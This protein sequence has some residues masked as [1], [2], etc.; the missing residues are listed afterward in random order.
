MARFTELPDEIKLQILGHLITPTQP[1]HLIQ[2][3]LWAVQP[4][5]LFADEDADVETS[6]LSLVRSELDDIFFE[7]SQEDARRMWIQRVQWL[8]TSSSVSDWKALVDKSNLSIVQYAPLLRKLETYFGAT[9]AH[10]VI[11][12]DEQTFPRD[13]R[14]QPLP[15]RLR[16][17][18]IM[19]EQVSAVLNTCTNLKSLHVKLQ[20]KVMPFHSDLS[21]PSKFDYFYRSDAFHAVWEVLAS[22]Y[23][24]TNAPLSSFEELLTTWRKTCER[25]G[26]K[27]MITARMDAPPDTYGVQENPVHEE[28]LTQFWDVPRCV[29]VGDF[30]PWPSRCWAGLEW[31]IRQH[32]G[33]GSGV[34]VPRKRKHEGMTG[35]DC[36]C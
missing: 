15:T 26:I 18:K 2:W 24:D 9:V 10:I 6:L 19:T 13:E 30:K 12:I 31:A 32:Q 27:L 3:Q 20:A 7:V 14:G 8:V 17:A 29:K 33:R 11:V 1:V 25:R 28:D 4:D 36:E 16:W 35:L 23:A 5:I 22:R 34:E 21:V